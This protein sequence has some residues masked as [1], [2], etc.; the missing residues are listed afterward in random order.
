M[1]YLKQKRVLIYDSFAAYPVVPLEIAVV[2]SIS[3]LFCNIKILEEIWLLGWVESKY[4][5]FFSSI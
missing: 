4:A 3:F 2:L 5:Y 1:T